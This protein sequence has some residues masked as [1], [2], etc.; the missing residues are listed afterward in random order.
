MKKTLYILLITL[1]TSF[2]GFSQEKVLS[3][4]NNS[5]NKKL[6]KS[7]ASEMNW[8]MLQ[9]T[10]KVQIGKVKTE[11]QKKKREYICYNHS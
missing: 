1:V 4:M 6:L 10:H 8:F 2:Q 7:E 9:D 5:A 11:I 3:P